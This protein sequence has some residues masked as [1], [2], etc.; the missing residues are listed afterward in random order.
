VEYLRLAY[1]RFQS[2]DKL[3]GVD[4]ETQY[5]VS[6]NKIVVAPLKVAVKKVGYSMV[7]KGLK[8]QS[9]NSLFS[10]LLVSQPKEVVP[11]SKNKRKGL[12]REIS[13]LKGKI[14]LITS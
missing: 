13:V 2:K 3:F 7:A 8:R 9:T 12:F 6:L 5:D 4:L 11:H 10:L 1:Y 14:V